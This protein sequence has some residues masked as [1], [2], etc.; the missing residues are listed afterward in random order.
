MNNCINI[1]VFVIVFSLLCLFTLPCVSCATTL[2]DIQ[3][4]N[5]ENTIKTIL[6][7]H[8][9]GIDPVLGTIQGRGEQAEYG[10][11]DGDPRHTATPVPAAGWLFSS[12]L[13]GLIGIKRKL[14][15]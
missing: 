14:Q 7:S 6:Y 5:E 8:S 4:G 3:L 11:S 12:G 2:S 9:H 15:K 1:N 10:R 13:V